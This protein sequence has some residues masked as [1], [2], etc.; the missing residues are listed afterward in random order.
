MT[1]TAVMVETFIGADRRER[2]LRIDSRIRRQ[3]KLDF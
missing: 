3:L 1:S 2:S